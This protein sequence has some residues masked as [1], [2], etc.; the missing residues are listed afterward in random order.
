M[1][2]IRVTSP[3]DVSPEVASTIRMRVIFFTFLRALSPSPASDSSTVRLRWTPPR[4]RHALPPTL[5]RSGRRRTH[6]CTHTR[7]RRASATRASRVHRR[8]C[9]GNLHLAVRA[10]TVRRRSYAIFVPPRVEGASDSSPLESARIYGRDDMTATCEILRWK[11]HGDVRLHLTPAEAK[12]NNYRC[13][14]MAPSRTKSPPR[15]YK[16]TES[17]R[18]HFARWEDLFKFFCNWFTGNSDT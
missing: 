18:A 16:T 8:W 2:T 3:L 13:W 7:Q 12:A 9:Q 14:F 15:P 6:A 10:C 1:H 17:K 11:V 5:S 4:W